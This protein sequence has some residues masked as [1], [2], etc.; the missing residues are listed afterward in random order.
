M[1][2][3]IATFDGVDIAEEE[4]TLDAVRER[5][6]PLMRGMA[7]FR[8]Y[9]ELVDRRAGRALTVSFFDSEENMQAAESTFEEEMPKQLGE[10]MGPWAGRRSAVDR[11][12]VLV[13]E[14]T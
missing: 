14:R 2:A 5:V 6:E 10:L 3:R 11:Y 7:G 8:G 1:F 9:M 12:E 13:D 4:R